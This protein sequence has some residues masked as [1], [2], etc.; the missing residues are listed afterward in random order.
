MAETNKERWMK[1]IKA[2]NPDKAYENEDDMYADAMSGYENVR[3]RLKKHED[4]NSKMIKLLKK[5]PDVMGFI[6]VLSQTGDFGKAMAQLPDYAKMNDE[7]RLSYSNETNRKAKE[8]EETDKRAKAKQAAVEAAATV[9]REWA[10]KNGV[11]EEQFTEMMQFL[12]DNLLKKIESGEMDIDF[13]EKVYRLF[14]YDKDMEANREAGRIEGRNASFSERAQRRTAGDGL[15][16]IMASGTNA[17]ETEAKDPNKAALLG[18]LD[19]LNKKNAIH[20]F[21]R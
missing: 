19:R 9:G 21:N 18:T 6:S 4:E 15:P 7:E 20:R 8:R 14:N 12:Y 10:D 3:G 2:K 1:A 13:F 5:N 16:E 11:S 17:P